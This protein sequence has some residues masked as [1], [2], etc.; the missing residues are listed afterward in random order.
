MTSTYDVAVLGLGAMG[1]AALRYLARAG[2]SVVGFERFESP[3]PHGSSHGGSRIIREA[4]FEDPR[5]V[6]LVQRAYE[7]WAALERDTGRTLTLTTGGVMIGP[8]EGVLVSGA[9]ASAE[10]HSLAYELLDVS[11]LQ[12]RFPAFHPAPHMVGV[13]EPRAGALFPEECIAAHLEAA[14]R[15]GAT[16]RAN[17]GAVSWRAARGEVEVTT[18]R[19]I[20]RARQLVL[21]T[22]AWLGSHVAA[23]CLPLT[24][25][26]VVQVWFEPASHPEQLAPERCPITIWEYGHDQFFYAF[27]LLNGA[28]KAALHHQGEVTDPDRVRREVT[29]EEIE[30]IRDPL[31]RHIPDAAGRW[32]DAKTCMYANTPDEH[33]VLDRHPDHPEVLVVSAC[34]GHGFKFASAIGAVIAELVRDGKTSADIGL[35]ELARFR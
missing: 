21:S 18:E 11:A 19:G 1:S 29:E 10:T 20:T 12:R 25:E 22:G 27:P 14:A 15:A 28:V 34:S 4:Y 31:G 13:W 24:I 3:H 8:R 35:F 26:R 30:R 23:T 6:P 2:L 9:I 16:V 17:E 5:Y 33:F 32:L 7:E